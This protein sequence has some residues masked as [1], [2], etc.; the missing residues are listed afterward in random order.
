MK[1]SKKPGLGFSLVI[2]DDNNPTPVLPLAQASQSF[3]SQQ[4]HVQPLLP[5]SKQ[6]AAVT[7][8]FSWV[9]K[10]L[11]DIPPLEN[12]HFCF[13][14]LIAGPQSDPT[15]TTFLAWQTDAVK[16]TLCKRGC[17][18]IHHQAHTARDIP[19]SVFTAFYC[20]DHEAG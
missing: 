1:R 20:L 2:R 10:P 16:S 11:T 17:T 8:W 12:G 7:P 14:G 6:P 15:G 19:Q 4:S 5:T 18:E 9:V 3:R 13:L